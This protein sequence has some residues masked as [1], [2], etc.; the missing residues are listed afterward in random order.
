MN[1]EQPLAYNFDR[2]W[3]FGLQSCI[4]LSF[5]GIRPKKVL[6]QGQKLT[7]SN[8]L[9]GDGNKIKTK[10]IGR[11]EIKDQGLLILRCGY[12]DPDMIPGLPIGQHIR[13]YGYNT[14]HQ[15]ICRSYT[16]ITRADQ[17]VSLF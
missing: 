14:L 3:S 12:P 15:P 6:K 5:G 7:K 1:F 13:L 2:F 17:P 10:I 8:F 4:L 16:P 9:K 11:K